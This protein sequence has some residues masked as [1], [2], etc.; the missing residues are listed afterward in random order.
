VDDKTHLEQLERLWM[1]LELMK[2][3]EPDDSYWGRL[4]QTCDEEINRLQSRMVRR[5]T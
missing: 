2:L 1:N 5:Y 3:L 4:E